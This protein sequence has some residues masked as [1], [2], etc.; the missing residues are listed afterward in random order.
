MDTDF[1]SPIDEIESKVEASARD[2]MEEIAKESIISPDIVS[3][4]ATSDTLLT[5]IGVSSIQGVND[6]P[7]LQPDN[8]MLRDVFDVVEDKTMILDNVGNQSLSDETISS[9]K[10]FTNDKFDCKI[11][12][13]QA[14]ENKNLESSRIDARRYTSEA[15][16]KA[17]IGE[18]A[19]NLDD[20]IKENPELQFKGNN[21]PGYDI[22]S[23]NELCSVKTHWGDAKN[24]DGKYDWD[25]ADYKRD[26]YRLMGTG[27]EINVLSN[28]AINL[29]SLID[30]GEIPYPQELNDMSPTDMVN[31]VRDKTTL[32]IPDDHVDGLKNF[33]SEDYQNV[34]E[35]YH[36]ASKEDMLS[37]IKGI[38]L[39]STILQDIINAKISK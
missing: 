35:N 20:E 3:E 10:G 1:F 22:I 16:A 9:I 33:L 23:Q 11:A 26:L 28:D 30:T 29:K 2:K 24:S 5:D 37:R 13:E 14:M 32:R 31:F 4:K 21:Y 18:G 17:S 25:P 27:E 7:V 6:L 19:V 38:G 34:P 36:G 39:T 12:A 15:A 8:S